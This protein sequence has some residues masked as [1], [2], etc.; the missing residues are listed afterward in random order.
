MIRLQLRR[1]VAVL[2]AASLGLA[3]TTTASANTE[4]TV[5]FFGGGFGHG[6]GMS[7]Y[8]ALGRAE[9]GHSAEEILA[10]YYADTTIGSVDG[11]G[12][13]SGTTND[14]VD[15]RLGIRS[16]VTVSVP[17]IDGAPDPA[18]QVTV[19]ANGSPIATAHAPVTATYVDGRWSAVEHQAQPDGSVALVELCTDACVGVELSFWQSGGDYLVLEESLGGPNLGNPSNGQ[20]GAYARGRIVLHPA[21][22]GGGCGGGA[23]FC[24]I[25]A[26]LDLQH[27]LLGIAEVPTS[28]PLA[29]QQAQAIAAR[30]YAASAMVRR[31]GSGNAWDLDSTTQD[32][33]YVGYYHELVCNLWCDGVNSTDNQV[34]LHDGTIAETYYSSSNGGHSAE[35]PDVWAFGTTRPYLPARPD[36]FDGIDANPNRARAHTYTIDQV[37]RWLN[38]YSGS[39]AEDLDIGTLVGIEID[40]PPSGRIGFAPVVLTGTERTSLITGSLLYAALRS[41]CLNEPAAADCDPLRSTN[42]RLE[43]ITSFLDVPADNF[44]YEPVQWMALQGITGG[45]EPGLFAP[46]QSNTR[47]EL[48]TFLWRFADEPAGAAPA[49]FDDVPAGAFFAQAVDWMRETGITTGTS[50]TEFTP[51]DEVTRWETAVF[52]WRFAGSPA[53]DTEVDFV[54]IEPDA[55]YREAVEWMVEW[56]ITNGTSD[57]EFSPERTLT[58]AEIAAFLYRLSQSPEAYELGVTAEESAEDE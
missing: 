35:P 16:T 18:Y 8:G 2:L 29:A 13:F 33:Y 55:F 11:H 56:Q 52:L 53:S 24:V 34:V 21:A 32:Q 12:G 4:P 9:A 3:T 58:R 39:G 1:F 36:P 49:D 7:Q 54:D 26:D 42:F 47:A 51:A 37:S 50:Q 48:A 10:H 25:H 30:G 17:W 40:A 19:L 45:I 43:S 20:V 31:A 44:F 57:T 46:L 38:D 6:I 14:D 22:L 28:W 41:G 23:Q 5:T 15:V 27:Y